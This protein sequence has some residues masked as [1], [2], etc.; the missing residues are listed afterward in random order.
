MPCDNL[1][2]YY[3]PGGYGQRTITRMSCMAYA[4]SANSTPMYA[5]PY[6]TANSLIQRVDQQ[7]ECHEYKHSL[8]R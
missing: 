3:V 8:Q 6:A 5:R 7:G 4:R 2:R 1:N